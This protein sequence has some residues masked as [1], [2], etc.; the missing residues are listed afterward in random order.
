M[1]KCHKTCK[2]PFWLLF[3]KKLRLSILLIFKKKVLS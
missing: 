2:D 1:W 3:V